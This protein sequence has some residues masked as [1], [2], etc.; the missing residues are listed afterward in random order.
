MQITPT[1]PPPPHIMALAKRLLSWP[2][3]QAQLKY[4][5]SVQVQTQ[6]SW[7]PQWSA[8][9]PVDKVGQA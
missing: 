8:P 3:N 2:L 5:S 9:P 6:V 1:A 4:L 7:R